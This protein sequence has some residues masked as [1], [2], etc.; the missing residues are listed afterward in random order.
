MFSLC[1]QMMYNAPNAQY[2]IYPAGC[3]NAHIKNGVQAN[4]IMEPNDTYFD[5]QVIVPQ[6]AA[7]ISPTGRDKASIVPT[8]EATDFPPVKPKNTDLL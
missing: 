4:A 5:V 6:I 7:V 2:A 8:P 1:N 3:L